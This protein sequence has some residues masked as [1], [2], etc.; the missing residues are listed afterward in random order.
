MGGY[1]DP[2]PLL[3]ADDPLPRRPRRV[4]VAGTSGS[5]KTTVA[6]RVAEA[7]DVPHIEIDA[8][9]H[10][11]GWT[12]RESFAADVSRFSAGPGWVTE[13]QYDRVRDLLADRADLV[14]WLDLGRATVMYQVVRRTLRRRLTREELWNGNVEPP[15]RTLVTDREHIVRWAWSTHGKSAVRVA[16]LLGRRPE[17]A[18]VRLRN[19]AGLDRWLAGALQDAA[20]Q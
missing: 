3:D 8:L 4:L 5:G 14:V 6:R 16:T 20:A 18:V 19:R 11:P 2:V 9:F 17:L 1:R 13:W 7:L 10:G 12:P 15:L